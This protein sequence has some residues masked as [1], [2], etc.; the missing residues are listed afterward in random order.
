MS[1]HPSF[2]ELFSLVLAEQGIPIEAQRVADA[3]EAVAPTFIE[4]LDKMP[5][6]AWS[7]S[8]EL[9]RRFWGAVYATAFGP[10]E[11][12]DPEGLIADAMYERFTRYESYRLFSDALPA[13]QDLEKRGLRLGLISNF[14]DWLEGMLIEMEVAPFFEVLVVSGVEGIEKPD[15]AIFTAALERVGVAANES[16][17]VGD[18]PRVDVEGAEAVGMKGILLDRKDRYP[19]FRGIRIKELTDLPAALGLES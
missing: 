12:D 5:D 10:L 4:V 2:H 6:S 15:P 19:E 8:P 14:E 11:V 1:P 9:S 7:T 13:L 18:H 3:F 17:Y 16:A